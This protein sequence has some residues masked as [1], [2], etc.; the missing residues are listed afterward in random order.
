[1]SRFPGRPPT[2]FGLETVQWRNCRMLGARQIETIKRLIWDA[3]PLPC[4]PLPR[5]YTGFG[6]KGA[7]GWSVTMTRH[8]KHRRGKATIASAISAISLIQP[9]IRWSE[10][11][12]F[13]TREIQ[14][15]PLENQ[16][17]DLFKDADFS[18]CENFYLF[19]DRSD[20]WNGLAECI[21][22]VSGSGEKERLIDY[23]DFII[24]H[25]FIYFVAWE[26]LRRISERQKISLSKSCVFL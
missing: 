13:F 14:F 20:F 16:V 5:V 18:F 10:L 15:F 23:S 3:A 22:R 21:I 7:S 26:V 8:C 19:R 2:R 25:F 6:W 12:L 24:V 4:A 17:L 9:P 11:V 1:M